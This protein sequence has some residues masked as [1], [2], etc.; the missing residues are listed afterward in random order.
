MKIKFFVVFFSFLNFYC[1]TNKQQ[2]ALGKF[3]IEQPPSLQVG[4]ERLDLYWPLIQDKKVA[5]VVN[6]TS[7]MG[8]MH[9]IDSL[10]SLGLDIARIFAPEHG[11]RGT[12]DAGEKIKDGRDIATGIP[13][14]SLYGKKRK[15]SAEDLAGV[16]WVIFDIQDVGAR[17]YTYISSMHYVM[18]ACA[19]QGISFMV[20]DRPNP[21]GHY[22]DGPVLDPAFQSFVGMHEIPVV[23]G[24]TVGEYASMVNEEGWLGEESKCDLKVIPCAGYTHQTPYTIPIKPSPNLPNNRAIYLYPSLCFFEGTQVSIGRGTDKQFQLIG[25]PDYPSEEFAFT[26]MPKPGARYP[27]HQDQLC[28]GF[29][30]TKREEA[31]IRK[32]ARINLSYL[33][34]VYENAPKK[35]QFF[36]QSN[37]FDKLAGGESLREQVKAGWS[38]Q[39]IRKSWEPELSQFKQKRKKYLLYP[40]EFAVKD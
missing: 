32:E 17:F 2:P 7:R 10:H 40:D 12:A 39:Q 9:V 36:L 24:M 5:F 33:I 15:P 28:K 8:S 16:D 30:L 6:Q 23:H 22:V 11:F 29:D 38:E 20:L 1:S 4:A 13:I 14:T 34:E 27:K 19:E 3:T 37:F 31:V 26:P 25:L 21:N 35:D 18:Q